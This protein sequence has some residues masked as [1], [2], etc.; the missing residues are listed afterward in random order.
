MELIMSGL[1]GID[2][3]LTLTF[4]DVKFEITVFLS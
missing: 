3:V 2:Y 4:I 1:N